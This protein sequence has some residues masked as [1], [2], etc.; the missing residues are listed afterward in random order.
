MY[1]D[2]TILTDAQLIASLKS[3]VIDERRCLVA[4][5][6]HLREMDRRHLADKSGFPSLFEYC[7][8]ELRYAHGS[9]ARLIHA[10]RAATKHPVLYR[11]LE[12]GLLSLT[13]VSMLAPYLT[14]KNY[15]ELIRSAMGRTTR[16]VEALVASLSPVPAAPVERVRI[17]TVAAPAP[18]VEVADLFAPPKEPATPPIEPAAPTP[19]AE[20]V[21]PTAPACPAAAARSVPPV[22]PVPLVVRRVHFSF[23]GDE[24]FLRDFERAKELSRHKWPAGKLE[25]VFVGAIKVLLEKID[26]ERRNRRK[27]RVRRLVAG[28]RSRHILKSVKDEVWSRDGGRCAFAAPGGRMCGARS[29]LEFDHVRPWA[30]GGSG[31]TGNIRLLCRSHN[32]LEARRFFGG[33]AIDAAVSRRRLALRRGVEI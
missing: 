12:R 8:R 6:R 31:E 28:V 24:A 17:L 21:A 3:L 9:T 27:E 26:P 7:V 2:L 10:S 1:Q 5:L 25:D 4:V 30:L 33:A 19:Q 22:A 29:G 18:R 14:R 15:R 11:A 23:T 20:A 16:E 32:Q 13:A